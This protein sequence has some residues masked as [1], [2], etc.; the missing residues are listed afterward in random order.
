MKL[1]HYDNILNNYFFSSIAVLSG[2]GITIWI[3]FG[4]QKM[5]SKRLKSKL[6][7]R[8]GQVY[9]LFYLWALIAIVTRIGT[10]LPIIFYWSAPI[11]YSEINVSRAIEILFPLISIVVF[12]FYWH[13]FRLEFYIGKWI[14]FSFLFIV[15]LV[16]IF[17]NVKVIDH[18]IVDNAY[19]NHYENEFSYIDRE[20]DNAKELGVDFDQ[21]ALETLKHFESRKAL[22]QTYQI[23][24]VFEGNRKI[25]IDTLI[26]EKILIHNLRNQNYIVFRFNHLKNWSYA[27]PEEIYYQIKMYNN[28][29]TPEVKVLFEI[30][31]EMIIQFK[32]RELLAK[33][34]NSFDDF[35]LYE[36]RLYNRYRNLDYQTRTILSRLVQVTNR[37]KK[38]EKYHKYHNLLLDINMNVFGKDSNQKYYELD[39]K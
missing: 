33:K 7:L 17:S 25:P 14:F 3:W 24:K 21:K 26:I 23:Q 15:G 30:L 4:S 27:L 35:S 13:I 8:M 19:K 2:F 18:N 31:R 11:T 38:E 1:P 16:F 34:I 9:A 22:M 36:Y 37:L 29:D 32:A 28:P 20:L 39:L 6:I 5:L 12:L 10:L